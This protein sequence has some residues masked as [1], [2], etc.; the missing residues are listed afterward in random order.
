ME[1]GVAP[2]AEHLGLDGHLLAHLQVLHIFPQLH[3]LARDLMPLG[4]RV[5]GVG[6]GAVINV[7]ITAADADLLDLH[8]HLVGARLGH[9]DLPKADLAGFGHHL[10][11]HHR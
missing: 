4:Y 2:A 6:M 5:G 3:D 1:A 10:L 8:Q 9:G 7:D 11:L